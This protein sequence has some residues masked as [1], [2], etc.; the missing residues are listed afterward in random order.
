M[1]RS[2]ILAWRRG[3]RDE[4]IAARMALSSS[5]HNAASAAIYQRLT[6][7]F[8]TQPRSLIGAYW[9]FRREYDCLPLMR[10]IIDAG[11][12][13]IVTGSGE[14]AIEQ[15]RLDDARGVELAKDVGVAEVGG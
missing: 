14:P 5:E 3:K 1:E 7:L 2:E 10:R 12:Q 6:T 8:A 11:G 13:I 9:P 15:G 4:L